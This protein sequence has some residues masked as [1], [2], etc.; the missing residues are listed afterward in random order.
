[1]T[2]ASFLS[3]SSLIALVF[4]SACSQQG[5]FSEKGAYEAVQTGGRNQCQ[6]LPQAEYDRCIAQ[7]SKPYEEYERDR[8]ELEKK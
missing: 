6:N 4:I 8:E 3:L 5:S 7:Y 2:K 1:M